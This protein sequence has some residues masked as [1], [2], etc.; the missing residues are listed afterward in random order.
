MGKGKKGENSHKPGE[1]GD[2]REEVEGKWK[3]KWR[4]R[5]KDGV[6]PQGR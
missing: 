2:G 6:R 3:W 5:W 4:W 1:E